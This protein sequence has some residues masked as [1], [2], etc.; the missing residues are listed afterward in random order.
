MKT[1]EHGLMTHLLRRAGFGAT[2]D[3]LEEY[4]KIHVGTDG[5]GKLLDGD[6][7]GRI[8]EHQMYTKA[9][10]LTVQR[11]QQQAKAGDCGE[12][13]HSHGLISLHAPA[14][15]RYRCRS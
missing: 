4:A 2:R 14:R 12:Q 5:D 3:E 11:S 15:H 7:R 13:V 1:D 8:A 10:N 6:L 9:F